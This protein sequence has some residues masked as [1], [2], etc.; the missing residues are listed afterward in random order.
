M[1]QVQITA[2]ELIW[3]TMLTAFPT[4]KNIAFT[5]QLYWHI[6]RTGE[7]HMPLLRCQNKADLAWQEP[8]H[9]H[10]LHTPP[11]L[12]NDHR[13]DADARALWDYLLLVNKGAP[14]RPT[15]HSLWQLWTGGC[16]HLQTKLNLLNSESIFRPETATKRQTTWNLSIAESIFRAV[17]STKR[18]DTKERK[19][20]RHWAS[21]GEPWKA[22][23][24]W[25]SGPL[26]IW[27]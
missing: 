27:K 8:G 5:H 23:A 20:L 10:L 15:Q 9:V 14:R 1:W 17:I 24:A 2:K 22:K 19:T 6:N 21:W 16:C 18:K 12:T 11:R 13:N 4:A 3:Y 7:H 26:D 25:T